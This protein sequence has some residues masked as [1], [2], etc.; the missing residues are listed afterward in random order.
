VADRVDEL[1]PEVKTLFLS[2]H[3]DDAIERY[4]GINPEDN[5]LQK[6]F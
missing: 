5:F 4:G 1:R 3:L 6:P 2:G